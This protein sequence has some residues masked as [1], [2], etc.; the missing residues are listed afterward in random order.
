MTSE[1]RLRANRE[2]AKRSTGPKTATG[3]A[4]SARNARRHGLSAP[5][6]S[7]PKLA[8]AANELARRI[9][10][11]N[12]D[13]QLVEPARAVADAEVEILRARRFRRDVLQREIPDRADATSATP[14]VLE[15]AE[16][17]KQLAAADRYER[18]ALSRRKFAIRAFDEARRAP[19]NSVDGRNV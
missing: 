6:A 13:S 10:G 8:A 16:L 18:R 9:A 12:S 4:R 11:E 5:L 17:T 7:D 2:N 15:C 3:K 14:P 1:R 19:I